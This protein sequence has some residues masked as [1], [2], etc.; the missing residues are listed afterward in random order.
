MLTLD[1]SREVVNKA[2]SNLKFKSQPKEL[3]N[4]I[5][6][7]L[8]MGGKRLR[9]CMVIMACNL[10]RDD[11]EEAI[12]PAV[13]IEI[14]HNFTLLH[15][16]IMDNSILRRNKPTVHTKWDRNIAILSGDVMS[17]LSS[18]YITSCREEIVLDLLRIFNQT[19]LEVCEGQ[20]FDM[21]FETQ[22]QVDE[23]EYLKMIECKTA[24]LF[25]AS[26]KIG[27]IIGGASGSDAD[28]M[29]LF[30]KNL[31]MAFQLQD[32]LL[33]VYGDPEVFG[34]RIG[35]DIEANKKTYLLVKT[36]ELAREK[37]RNEIIRLLN[38]GKIPRKEKI[39][40]MVQIYDAINIRKITQEKVDF[41]FKE[42]GESL[43]RVR[44]N[45]SR[46]EELKKMA[47][48]LNRRER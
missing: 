9:P 10:F 26:L 22:F 43:E 18:S 39:H 12:R 19:A 1:D 45:D 25:A 28:N 47:D 48:K 2:I 36:L 46:K 40:A 34:K 27:S 16:D 24:V 20:Q 44:V 29:Y 38:D 17:I 3:Y 15:D 5:R 8:S 41:Y 42:A 6:Y 32:D 33:D 31:G 35:E 37:R 7:I 14:F 13:G 4:P 21:N 11:V 30:G 23:R